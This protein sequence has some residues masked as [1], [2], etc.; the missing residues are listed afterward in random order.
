[1]MQLVLVRGMPNAT[2]MGATGLSQLPGKLE[3]KFEPRYQWLSLVTRPQCAE[4]N[5]RY[6]A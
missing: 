2:G 1:M 5:Y 6:K 4:E 3:S